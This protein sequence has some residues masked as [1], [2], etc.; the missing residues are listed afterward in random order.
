[1]CSKPNETEKKYMNMMEKVENEIPYIDIKPF[2]HNIIN[3]ELRM[4]EELV[5][6]E[7]VVEFIRNNKYLMEK[8][9]GWIVKNWDEEHKKEMPKEL[10]DWIIQN[11]KDCEEDKLTEKQK[12]LFLDLV[13]ENKWS[14]DFQDAFK[15]FQKSK[16]KSA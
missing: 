11:Y 6:E 14:K 10:K 12:T 2:S 16:Q 4:M 1:M 9:W 13:E 3:L 7:R 5:G 15:E 8:G